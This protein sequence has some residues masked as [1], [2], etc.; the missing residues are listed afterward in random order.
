MRIFIRCDADYEIGAGHAM[1]CLALAQKAVSEGY[2]VDFY[3][4]TGIQF[5]DSYLNNDK[6]ELIEVNS[7]KEFMRIV[8]N[9]VPDWIVLDGYQFSVGFERELQKHTRVLT[10][11]DFAHRDRYESTLLLNQNISALES[12]YTS[13]GME[14]G[15]LLLGTDYVLLREQFLEH[16]KQSVGNVQTIDDLLITLGGGSHTEVL[17]I[18]LAGIQPIVHE[19]ETVHVLGEKPRDQDTS[20]NMLFCSPF[21]NMANLLGRI[22][23]AISGGGST[24][25]ELLYLGVPTLALILADNQIELVK[26]LAE[27]GVIVSPGGDDGFESGQITKTLREVLRSPERAEIMAREG[28]KLVDGKGS[29]R[30]IENMENLGG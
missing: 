26:R 1:R 19:F 11:D 13:R 5:L 12:W 2:S 20:P 23:L 3:M 15:H 17:S 6:I 10:I 8:E 24:L 14:A 21:E 25:W 30:V 18:V 28:Q 22:D 7:D 9:V 16:E 29:S 27:R 4:K